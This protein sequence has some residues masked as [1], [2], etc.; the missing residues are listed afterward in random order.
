MACEQ[1]LERKVRNVQGRGRTKPGNPSMWRIL[2]GSSI[3]PSEISNARKMKRL[4]WSNKFTSFSLLATVRCRWLSSSV[5]RAGVCA[6]HA[7]AFPG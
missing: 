2:A 5:R 6:C 4:D 3:V 1:L 7:S